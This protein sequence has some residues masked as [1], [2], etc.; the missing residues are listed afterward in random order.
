MKFPMKRKL[1]IAGIVI[2]AILALGPMWASLGIATVTM[3]AAFEMRHTSGATNGREL[4]AKIR[5]AAWMR[6]L[7]WCVCPLGFGLCIFSVVKL[8]ANY[9][10]PP[11][12][13][14]K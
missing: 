7:G 8:Q 14:P 4:F 13:P 1:I 9:H 3:R 10:E 5:S 6:T 2:G 12:L 11:P